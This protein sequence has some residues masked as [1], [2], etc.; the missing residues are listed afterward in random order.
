MVIEWAVNGKEGH[1]TREP[2]GGV[3][4]G[5][6]AAA[7]TLTFTSRTGPLIWSEDKPEAISD[8]HLQP[9][10]FAP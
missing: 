2:G 7:A 8:L 10:I 9:H 3:G 1:R 6:A 4:G 5:E